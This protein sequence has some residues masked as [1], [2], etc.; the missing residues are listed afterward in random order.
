MSRLTKLKK[1]E[2]VASDFDSIGVED[3]K[4][5]RNRVL[6]GVVKRK[7]MMGHWVQI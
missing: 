7:S 5:C 3:I 1:N 6:M 4:E 2:V